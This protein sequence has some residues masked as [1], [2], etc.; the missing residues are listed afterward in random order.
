MRAP[1]ARRNTTK[2]AAK[3]QR[4][5][6][7]IAAELKALERRGHVDPKRV[8]DWAR[9]NRGSALHSCFEWDDSAAAERYRLWQARELIV[10]VHVIYPDG[11]PRQIY[12]SP[13]ITRGRGGYMRLAD[14]LSD[15]GRRA[16]FLR[17]ALEELERVCEKYNDLRELAGVRA[18]VRLVKARTRS[19]A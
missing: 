17:Q 7:R 10:R 19:A 1:V 16:E 3:P 4:K 18:A 9:I 8:V 6:A 2:A 14:V 5:S 13:I 11:K 15:S 12:V